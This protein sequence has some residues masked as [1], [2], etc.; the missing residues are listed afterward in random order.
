[1]PYVPGKHRRA[2]LKYLW[3]Y[4]RTGTKDILFS[5]TRQSR[6]VKILRT[7]ADIFNMIVYLILGITLIHIGV[8][9]YHIN[10]IDRPDG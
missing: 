1:M 2:Y 10:V 5:R 6:G 9:I 3:V 7:F 8:V 4:P